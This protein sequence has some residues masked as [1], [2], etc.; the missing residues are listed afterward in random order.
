M[1]N[2]IYVK[3]IGDVDG[4]KLLGFENLT[5]VPFDTRL[6]EISFLTVEEKDWINTYHLE[7]L[8]NVGPHLEGTTLE[9]LKDAVHQI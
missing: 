2:L 7:V 6:I 9:W 8:E 5:F 3:K 1:E 4:Q